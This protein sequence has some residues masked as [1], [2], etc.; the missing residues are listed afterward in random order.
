LPGLQL[1]GEPIAAHPAKL[2]SPD[3]IEPLCR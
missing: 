3:L 1:F 2:Y